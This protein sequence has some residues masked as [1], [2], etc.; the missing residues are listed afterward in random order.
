MYAITTVCN[1][2][3]YNTSIMLTSVCRNY[4]LVH[5]YCINIYLKVLL[6]AYHNISSCGFKNFFCT[7]NCFAFSTVLSLSCLSP[8]A[9]SVSS[10]LPT[11]ALCRL[12]VN[13]FATVPTNDWY[14]RQH[15]H[16]QFTTMRQSLTRHQKTSR[17]STYPRVTHVQQFSSFFHSLN[18]K[19]QQRK[20]IIPDVHHALSIFSEHHHQL[21]CAAWFNYSNCVCPS[22]AVLV[23]ND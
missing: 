3:I 15:K 7:F 10:V 4:V 1:M 23:L 22:H 6:M 19:Q 20:N 16:K 9:S 17:K 2:T 5:H 21:I 8:E 11:S 12:F 18:N 13:F 14:L